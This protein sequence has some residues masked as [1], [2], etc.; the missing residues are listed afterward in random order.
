MSKESRSTLAWGVFWLVIALFVLLNAWETFGLESHSRSSTVGRSELLDLDWQ[1]KFLYT[2]SRVP[3]RSQEIRGLIRLVYNELRRRIGTPYEG[4]VRQRMAVLEYEFGLGDPAET[5]QPLLELKGSAAF[6]RQAEIWNRLYGKTAPTLAELPSLLEGG[7][8]TQLGWYAQLVR[9]HAYERAGDKKQAERI[10][11]EIDEK[12]LLALTLTALGGLAGC[13]L[14]LVGLIVWA[15]YLLRSKKPFHPA[16]PPAFYPPTLLDRAMWGATLYLGGLVVSSTLLAFLGLYRAILYLSPLVAGGSALYFLLQWESRERIPTSWLRISLH[17]WS[18]EFLIGLLAYAAYL[19][20][21]PPFCC[22]SIWLLQW[23]PSQPNPVVEFSQASETV[24]EKVS[25]VLS[26][27]GVVPFFEEIIFR[28]VLFRALW[29]RTGKRL[30]SAFLSGLAFAAIHPQFLGGLLPI[31]LLGTF[32]AL[33][34]AE[35]GSLLPCIVV[36]ALNNGLIILL[37][38]AWS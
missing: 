11:A 3:S 30:L 32:L 7:D 26:S 27:C 29:Q 1:A 16:H 37:F 22:L 15:L 17:P 36:H 23:L 35:R 2:L 5:V 8:Q 6:S 14:F 12:L 4:A 20:L 9:A 33:L 13:T 19:V 31:T 24:W 28:G 38:M 21:V 25:L 34:Y 18:K 10:R